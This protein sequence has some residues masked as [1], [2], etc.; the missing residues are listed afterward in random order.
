LTVIPRWQV[1][2]VLE[3]VSFAFSVCLRRTYFGISL[4]TFEINLSFHF[5][6]FLW[7]FRNYWD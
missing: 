7:S 5:R 2:R 4:P 1:L 6:V 3:G